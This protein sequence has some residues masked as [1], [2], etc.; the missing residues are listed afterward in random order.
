MKRQD[1]AI[2]DA[3]TLIGGVISAAAA[4]IRVRDFGVT[5][6]AQV[7]VKRLSSTGDAARKPR[8]E[9]MNCWRRVKGMAF[10]KAHGGMI[11]QIWQW[12]EV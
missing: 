10:G 2:S 5:K 3:E 11:D 12:A 8:K 4:P 7:A 9:S 1:S 6:T